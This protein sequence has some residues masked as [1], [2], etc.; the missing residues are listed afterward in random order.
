[1]AD[2]RQR[3][4]LVVEDDPTISA[5]LRIFLEDSGCRIVVAERGEEAVRLAAELRP[6]LITLDL[7]LPDIDGT[8]VLRQIDSEPGLAN[9]PVVVVTARRYEARDDERV[10]AVLQKPFDATELEE[11]VRRALGLA[12]HEAR[13]A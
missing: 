5:I 12:N 7:A 8:E 9:V 3:T 1:M 2:P 4:I 11:T 10:V 6:A 13:G